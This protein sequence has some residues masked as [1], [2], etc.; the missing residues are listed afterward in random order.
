MD[1]EK[2]GMGGCSDVCCPWS[3]FAIPNSDYHWIQE[4]EEKRDKKVKNWIFFSF[5]L[6]ITLFPIFYYPIK[7]W[8][9]ISLN[10]LKAIECEYDR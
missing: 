10:I 9:E 4:T 5:I 7:L 1:Y 8:V 2:Y 6:K 3:T